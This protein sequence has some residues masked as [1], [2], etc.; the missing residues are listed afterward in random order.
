MS[1]CTILLNLII[2]HFIYCYIL[3][4]HLFY[5]IVCTVFV[6][7]TV[8]CSVYLFLSILFYCVLLNSVIF[9]LIPIYC[10]LF[11]C[12]LLHLLYTIIYYSLYSISFSTYFM[13]FY[14]LFCFIVCWSVKFCC[15]QFYSF[16][17]RNF[18]LYHT[19]LF[20][21]ILYI[22]FYT[23]LIL[24]CKILLDWIISI[25]YLLCCIL[26]HCFLNYFLF[27]SNLCESV[28]FWYNLFHWFVLLVIYI[29]H[30][31]IQLKYLIFHFVV[32]FYFTQLFSVPF[33]LC[34]ILLL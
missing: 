12:I 32:T 23:G 9:L 21:S 30:N 25:L 8:F 6:L 13:L 27:H 14:S 24:L 31:S 1:L 15:I 11:Y 5:S 28:K 17:F 33:V 29:V 26:I 20:Y 18:I 34:S 22:A 10:N 2:F 4:H 7:F 16:G 19:V 3:Y